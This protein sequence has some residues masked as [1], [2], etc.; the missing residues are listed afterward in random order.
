MAD[1][2]KTDDNKN[3]VEARP[4]HQGKDPLAEGVRLHNTSNSSNAKT[5]EASQNRVDPIAHSEKPD[6]Q[7]VSPAYP[8]HKIPNNSKSEQN[9]VAAGRK[10]K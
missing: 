7:G 9:K 5:Y 2:K 3:E 10:E 4:Q 6:N 8:V 1:S